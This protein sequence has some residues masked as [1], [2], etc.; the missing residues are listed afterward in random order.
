LLADPKHIKHQQRLAD[1]Y[2]PPHAIITPG[3]FEEVNQIARAKN[4]WLL[5]NVHH[6]AQFDCLRIN[7]DVWSKEPIQQ[8]VRDYFVLWYV[9][10]NTATAK[11]YTSYYSA[12]DWPHVAVLDPYTGERLAMWEGHK[13][14][15]TSTALD[16]ALNAFVAKHIAELSQRTAHLSDAKTGAASEAKNSAA[17]QRTDTAHTNDGSERAV[18]RRRLADD[19][20]ERMMNMAIMASMA[21]EQGHAETREDKGREHGVALSRDMRDTGGNHSNTNNNN[22]NTSSNNNNDSCDT[23][24]ES[25]AELKMAPRN[26]T[27]A[28]NHSARTL[29]G[30]G[31]AS[32]HTPTTTTTPTTTATPITSVPSV[33]PL[34]SSAHSVAGPALQ[35][36]LRL[37]SARTEPLS[38][39]ADTPLHVLLADTR[40][41]LQ[42]PESAAVSLSS[43]YPRRTFTASQGEQSLRALGIENKSVLFVDVSE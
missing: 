9:Y 28:T 16:E 32:S 3:N 30:G 43:N 12:D 10:T 25:V 33:S 20:E 39:S 34:A 15:A 8:L 22:N 17:N 6:V 5:I 4:K 41:L 1:L 40:V 21:E 42:L 14:G 23:D 13:Y 36:Q 2:R 27:V 26:T 24:D 37:P 35:L 29:S 19:E 38:Y 31:T 11:P 18:K 7:R